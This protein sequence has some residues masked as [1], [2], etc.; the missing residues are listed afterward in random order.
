MQLKKIVATLKYQRDTAI[1]RLFAARAAQQ[2][3]ARAHRNRR[4]AAALVESAQAQ[5]CIVVAELRQ[6]LSIQTEKSATAEAYIE[7]L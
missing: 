1:Q 7:A 3:A 2:K 6:V 5:V 4:E